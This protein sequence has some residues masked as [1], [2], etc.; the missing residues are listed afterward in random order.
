MPDLSYLVPVLLLCRVAIDM[1]GLLSGSNS[2]RLDLAYFLVFFA[3]GIAMA[4]S[5]PI[6]VWGVLAFGISAYSLLQF[7]V[8]R[9]AHVQN[10]SSSA[11]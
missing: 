6:D 3:A 5:G 4:S 7:I 1:V 2:Y 11:T 10:K 9:T 8:K